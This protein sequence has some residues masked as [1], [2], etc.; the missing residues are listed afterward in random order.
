VDSG[1]VIQINFASAGTLIIPADATF[2]FP[3]GTQMVIFQLGPGRIT[4][5]RE[6]AGMN[7]YFEGGRAVT[8]GQYAVASLIKLSAN[9]WILSGNLSV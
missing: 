9:G 1:K 2:N 6:T 3:I 5:A 7:L 8:V 4:F